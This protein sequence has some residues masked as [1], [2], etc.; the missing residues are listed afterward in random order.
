MLDTGRA[1]VPVLHSL[2]E[3]NTNPVTIAR[4]ELGQRSETVR[5]A[6]LSTVV[7]E[8]HVHGPLSRS[9]LV[10]RTG[11]TRSAIRSLIG[12]LATAASSRRSGPSRSGR[13]AA[14]PRS[15]A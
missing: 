9:D 11:L 7:R 10:A 1:G 4:D 12:E 6:N 8:L 13:P 3:R 5:R 15:S 14:R 2:D